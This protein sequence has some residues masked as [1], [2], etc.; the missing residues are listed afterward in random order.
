[1]KSATF[2]VVIRARGTLF[3]SFLVEKS[4]DE[5]DAYEEELKAIIKAIYPSQKYSVEVFEH[6]DEVCEDSGYFDPQY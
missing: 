5:V 4:W 3:K 6:E 1:M 2:N